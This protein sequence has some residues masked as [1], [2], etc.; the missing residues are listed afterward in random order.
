MDS[1]VRKEV[2]DAMSARPKLRN[3]DDSIMSPPEEWTTG[4]VCLA[5]TVSSW[6]DQ[7]VASIAQITGRYKRLC[8][9]HAR[10]AHAAALHNQPRR[11]FYFCCR[12]AEFDFL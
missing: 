4:L 1:V 11:R 8:K 12:P 3:C 10:D 9:R 7:G 2:R 5:P 6:D